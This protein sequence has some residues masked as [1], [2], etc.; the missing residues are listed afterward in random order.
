[1]HSSN[2]CSH[3]THQAATLCHHSAFGHWACSNKKLKS[4]HVSFY[5]KPMASARITTAKWS[6][7]MVGFFFTIAAVYFRC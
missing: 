2:L 7:L 6:A 1:M 5:H 4:L 3:P